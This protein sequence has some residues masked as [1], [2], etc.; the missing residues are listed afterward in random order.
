[1]K[2]K[3]IIGVVSAYGAMTESHNRYRVL[4][5]AE[6]DEEFTAK[7]RAFMCAETVRA[8]AT[9]NLSVN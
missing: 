5:H 9:P 6:N 8:R 4:I 1:M 7:L 2:N 3:K